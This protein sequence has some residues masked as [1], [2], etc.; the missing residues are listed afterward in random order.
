MSSGMKA[1]MMNLY[2]KE[3]DLQNAEKYF[4]DLKKE[5]SSFIL[6]DHKLLD[7]VS[8]LIKNNRLNTALDILEK[9]PP[10]KSV[11]FCFD[12][13]TNCLILEFF[14]NHNLCRIR[15]GYSIEMNCWLLLNTVAIN[16]GPTETEKMFSLLTR[17][18]YCNSSN[19]ILGPLVRAHLIRLN[20]FIDPLM[21]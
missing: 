15:G 19:I 12:L 20:L 2:V 1:S 18:K 13:I 4:T 11:K 3:N 16:V 10:N 9:T 8:L 17:L 5:D 7:Y 6:D 21:F 14:F